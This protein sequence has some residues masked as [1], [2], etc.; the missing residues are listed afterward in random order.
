ML[1]LSAKHLG[2]ADII[3]TWSP[4]RLKQDGFLQRHADLF[5]Y[6]KGF[7][8]YAW[9]PYI[10][11][12][13]MYAAAEGDLIVYQDVG[14]REPIL[15]RH[16]LG[17]WNSYLD[18]HKLHCI[19]GVLIPWWGPN[20]IW[21]KRHTLAALGLDQP[22]YKECPQVQASWSVWRKCPETLRFLQEWSN[23]CQRRDIVSG[24]LPNGIAGEC[25]GF[26][27]HRW[28][29]SLLTLLT[30]R[31]NLKAIDSMLSPDPHINEKSCD[32]WMKRLGQS[33]SF[34]TTYLLLRIASLVY[35][36]L[37]IWPRRVGR[38]FHRKYL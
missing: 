10:I 29:Q 28:D 38:I 11:F 35:A 13:T 32:D 33:T 25:P 20:R 8:W 1:E 21:T 19:P 30:L 15:I 27:E 7:G 37:E 31:D 18:E 5:P 16:P 22:S 26:I 12:Q 9:K 2:E 34:S 23:L 4:K 36:Q 14:R 17:F 3:H 6:S 24:D